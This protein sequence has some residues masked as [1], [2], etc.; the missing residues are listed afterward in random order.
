MLFCCEGLVLWEKSL[1]EEILGSTEIIVHS[2]SVAPSV[3]HIVGQEVQNEKK[4]YKHA[5]VG[6]DLANS[7]ALCLF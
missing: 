3:D 4:V 7:L 1:L 2:E 5:G 6:Y